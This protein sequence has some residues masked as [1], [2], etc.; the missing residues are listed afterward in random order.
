M[1]INTVVGDKLAEWLEMARLKHDWKIEVKGDVKVILAALQSELGE[2][3]RAIARNDPDEHVISELLDLIIVALRMLVG[4]HLSGSRKSNWVLEL[5]KAR[6]TQL[7]EIG[8]Y[9]EHKGEE[10]GMHDY[11]MHCDRCG[12]VLTLAESANGGLCEECLDKAAREDDEKK[13]SVQDDSVTTWWQDYVKSGKYRGA[14]LGKAFQIINSRKGGDG[15]PENCFEMIAD[16]WTTYLELDTQ[17]LPKDVAMMMALMKIA[18]TVHLV[19]GEDSYIDACGYIALAE[20]LS[21]ETD[22]R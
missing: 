3:S 4:D 20:E 17:I 13:P 15:K 14:V 22:G 12:K 9:D 7:G 21:H 16:L 6:P 11:G 8:P 5:L 19:G 1:R 10:V 18:R 2:L